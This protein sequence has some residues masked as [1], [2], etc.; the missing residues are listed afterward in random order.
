MEDRE[1]SQLKVM[2]TAKKVAEEIFF[3]LMKDYNDGRKLSDLGSKNIEE[4]IFST[5]ELRDIGR[6]NGL[7]IM[8]D[9]VHNLIKSIESTIRLKGNK[10]EIIQLTEL[11][12]TIMKLKDVFYDRK[13]DFFIKSVKNNAV[14]ERLNR[15]FFEKIKAIIEVC[16]INTEM[17]MT[18]NKL[19]FSDAGDEFK[20]DKALI[21]QIKEEYI[22]S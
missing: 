20:D 5:E 19:L 6:Y 18:R 4:S 14:E 3:P 10:E 21:K 8:N 22:G 13:D 15:H 2:N 9:S 17:L 1:D 12:K 16:Y 11:T 7:K